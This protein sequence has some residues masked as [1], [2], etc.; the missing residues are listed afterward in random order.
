MRL[1]L[2][3]RTIEP[4]LT[5][6]QAEKEIRRRALRSKIATFA[7]SVVAGVASYYSF[8]YFSL[9]AEDVM[10]HNTSEYTNSNNPFALLT[11]AEVLAAAGV[12]LP[13]ILSSVERRQTANEIDA[14]VESY[15]R[16]RGKDPDVLENISTLHSEALK[17]PVDY[18]GNKG[19]GRQAAFAPVVATTTPLAIAAIS[20]APSAITLTSTS[21][22]AA[23][24]LGTIGVLSNEI[25]CYANTAIENVNSLNDSF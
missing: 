1:P 17:T 22:A 3:S 8:K 23:V 7:L 5:S 9:A 13:T 24:G 25:Q 10:Q 2:W 12:I 18:N 11:Q 19:A 14:V 6:E 4:I 15:V 20:E 21:I 16:F